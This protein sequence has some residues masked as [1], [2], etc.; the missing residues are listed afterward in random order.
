MKATSV[1]G[2]AC[3]TIAGPTNAGEVCDNGDG[4]D[5]SEDGLVRVLN[6]LAGDYTVT[7]STATEGFDPAAAEQTAAVVAQETASLTFTNAESG[8]TVEIVKTDE[9]DAPLAGSCFELQGTENYGPVCDNG[10]GDADSDPGVIR[11]ESVAEGDY[12]VVETTTPENYETA[13]NGSV[14]VTEGEVST[15][16]VQ[17]LPPP[18]AVQFVKT[19]E[20]GDPLGEACFAL[21]GGDGFGPVCDNGDGD[22]DDAEGS[23]LIGDVPAGDYG[24]SETEAPEGYE[25]AEGGNVTVASGETATVE[26]QNEPAPPEFGAVEVVKTDEN[27]DPLAESCFSL[28]GVQNYGP[29]CDNDGN[30]TNDAEGTLGFAEVAP[31]DYQAVEASTPDGYQTAADTPVTVIAG[32]TATVEVENE[33]VP[34]ENGAVEITKTDEN[35][36]LLGGACF[37]LTGP[38]EVAPVCDNAD[39]DADNETGVILIEDVAA[40]EYTVNEAT[41]PTGY[42]A[43]APTP[44]TVVE[45]ETAELT[46]QNLLVPPAVGSVTVLAQGTDSAPV[47][48]ACYSVTGG[49]FS[50][51]ICDNAPNDPDSTIGSIGFDIVPAVEVTVTETTAPTGYNPADP[52]TQTATVMAD[53]ESE[54]T[55]AHTA[56]DDSGETGTVQIE[57]QSEDGAPAETD[58]CFVLRSDTD[59]LGPFCDN[60][61]GDTDDAAGKILVEDV[62]TGV[63]TVVQPA[64]EEAQQNFAAAAEVEGLAAEQK[65]VTVQANVIVIVIIIIIIVEPTEGDL[66]IR[67]EDEHGNLLAG[68]CFTLTSLDDSEEIVLCDGDEDDGSGAGGLIRFN[69]IPVGAFSLT[70]STPPPGYA[71]VEL[72]NIDIAPGGVV[73]ITVENEPLDETGQLVVTKTDTEDNPLPGACWRI[74]NGQGQVVVPQVCDDADGDDD[75]VTT[76]GEVPPGDWTLREMVAPDGYELAPNRL[77]HIISGQPTEVSVEDSLQPG[78]IVVEKRREGPNGNLLAGACFRLDGDTNYDEICDK[79]DGLNDGRTRFL[80]VIPGDYD[81]VETVT[82]PGYQTADPD[83]VTAVAGHSVTI[84]IVDVPL[85]NPEET[86]RLVIHKV[87]QN[88]YALPGACFTLRQG[89]ATVVGEVCDEDDGDYDG[90]IIF[91]EV[92]VGTYQTHETRKPSADYQSVAPVEV[93]IVEN[94]TTEI[95]IV[96]TLRLGRIVIV[97]TNQQGHPLANACFDVAPDG[98]GPKCTDATG[99]VA[100]QGLLPGKYSITETQAPQGYLTTAPYNNVV[101]KPGVTTVIEVVDKK[102]PPPPETGSVRIIKFYCTAGKGGEFTQIFDSSN[103]GS[104]QQLTK[105]AGCSNGV[106]TF[107][108]QRVGGE[109]GPGQVQTGQN[110]TYQT[111]LGQGT[112]RLTETNPDLPGPST[113]DFQIYTGQQTT[114]VVINWVKPP[115]PAPVGIS[116]IKYTC[117]PG[118]A[119]TYYADFLAACGDPSQLTNGVTFRISGQATGKAVTGDGGQKGV[120]G[121]GKLPAGNYTIKEEIPYYTTAYIFCGLDVNNPTLK[122]VNQ[123]ISVNLKPGQQLT[124]VA[125]NVPP[126][127]TK[128]TGS[129]LIHKLNCPIKTPP[130]GYNYAANCKPQTFSVQFS[131]S[132]YNGETKKFEPKTTGGTNSDGLLRFDNLTPGTYE[133]T[134]VGQNWCF[135]ES[136]SVNSKGNVIVKANQLAEVWIYN[137][138]PTKNPPNTGAGPMAS[139]SGGAGGIGSM[140]GIAFGLVWPLAAGLGFRLRRRRAA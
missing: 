113:E 120:T 119:G 101:V 41:V 61:D 127:V 53:T 15:V 123:P 122:A 45:G 83:Q 118:Y 87:D 112:Y 129:I 135:A 121:F 1:L 3:Y 26:V 11:L 49:G 56:V 92:G 91:E 33:P 117:D 136:T 27:G 9:N 50:A 2:G 65:T 77:V 25:T 62:P 69:D 19:D 105:T 128:T 68:A 126:Q 54:V 29:V 66:L 38:S 81:V 21:T 8:G 97:K 12:S 95:E 108:I 96:N 22:G 48:D 79:D 30:D 57:L 110:G 94:E 86:G 116:V 98:K 28:T 44:V 71:A 124:C 134:E 51:E 115:P 93:E 52:A 130:A 7:Q 6:L 132:I 59:E 13:A 84:V 40:G 73:Q 85:P 70:E 60:G 107:T 114:I 137:C 131:L 75:G 89:S 16:T 106:A 42:Q 78:T 31:G 64:A 100:F 80:G 10:N 102:A 35:N 133:L 103:P 99:Q 18:G 63:W 23:I 72:D 109:G 5:A 32:E 47:P 104:Q 43:A 55:F 4:D 82:P 37:G 36:E 58:E 24:W 34:V 17:N 76:F 74:Q 88:G 46:V 139:V 14:T 111:N 138:N 20:N 140:G 125:F 67:K 39:G 90:D